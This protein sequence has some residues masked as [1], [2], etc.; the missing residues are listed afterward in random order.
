MGPREREKITDVAGLARDSVRLTAAAA[1]AAA[2]AMLHV[3]SPLRQESSLPSPSDSEGTEFFDAHEEMPW[4]P[5]RPMRSARRSPAA[6]VT[7]RP[8]LGLWPEGLGPV[9]SASGQQDEPQPDQD[10]YLNSSNY[11]RNTMNIIGIRDGL[12]ARAGDELSTS[13]PGVASELGEDTEQNVGAWIKNCPQVGG[14][15]RVGVRVGCLCRINRPYSLS[16]PCCLA[17]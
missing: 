3:G 9:D 4:T 14:R 11:T 15:E 2:T 17:G 8:Q 16:S 13:T 1:T 7:K 10:P 5:D 12:Q 6:T